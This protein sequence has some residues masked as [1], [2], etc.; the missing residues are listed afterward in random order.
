L[1]EGKRNNLYDLIK[2]KQLEK[3]YTSIPETSEINVRNKVIVGLLVFQGLTTAEL[4]IIKLS[5]VDLE[6][7]SVTVSGKGKSS[8][9]C[10]PLQS[11]QLLPLLKYLE[12]YREMINPKKAINS[13]KLIISSGEGV[14]IQ[15]LLKVVQKRIRIKEEHPFFSSWMQIRCSVICSRLTIDNLRQQH[16]YFGFRFVSSIEE[17]LDN[18]VED[19]REELDRCFVL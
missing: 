17:Y 13:D 19:L 16:H 7:C 10:L 2:P 6:S 9:R 18:N 4:A 15:N 5:H 8:R 1:K 3:M 11:K 12:Q 14:K